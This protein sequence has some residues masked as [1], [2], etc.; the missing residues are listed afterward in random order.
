MTFLILVIATVFFMM[1]GEIINFLNK[2]GEQVQNIQSSNYD[3][4]N[5]EYNA[6]AQNTETDSSQE[7]TNVIDNS[8]DVQVQGDNNNITINQYINTDK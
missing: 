6:P 3:D 5:E 4:S 7:V 2:T 8:V 1:K